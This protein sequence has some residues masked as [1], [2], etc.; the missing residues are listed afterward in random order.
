MLQQIDAKVDE[1]GNSG[2]M[3]TWKA[4]ASM[5]MVRAGV[6]YGIAYAKGEIE[7]FDKAA[8][9]KYLSQETGGDVVVT[10]L[11]GLSNF[12]MFVAELEIF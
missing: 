9:T 6:E 8:I 2:R 1:N 5:A 11:D 12:L 7:K 3:A 4:P 10:E